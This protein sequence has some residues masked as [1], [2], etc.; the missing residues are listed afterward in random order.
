MAAAA[1][2]LRVYQPSV[3]AQAIATGSLQVEP[4]EPQQVVLY[5]HYASI[6]SQRA[7]LVLVEKQV[8]F[9]SVM[10]H[11]DKFE[12]ISPTYLGINPRGLVPTIVADGEVVFDSATIM[13]YVNNRFVGPD[14]TPGDDAQ[15]S[16]IKQ[17]IE[18]ADFF[19]IRD[20]VFRIAKERGEHGATY[21]GWG[22]DMVVRFI[23]T[24]KEY[25][26][27]YPEF[28]ENYQLK[29]QDWMGQLNRI[30]E[31]DT[32][33]NSKQ[34]TDETMD[35]FD[36]R[37]ASQDYI[38]GNEY[39]LADITWTPILIRLQYALDYKIWGDGLRPNLER[40]FLER[41]KARPGFKPAIIDHYYGDVVPDNLAA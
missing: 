35:E 31:D 8:S 11:Y 24:M 34:Y 27:Q 21:S 39:S 22:F 17:E 28:S 4:S 5:S 33:A 2:D 37:L 26:Q 14:L 18:T 3:R 13:Q 25:Q 29:L 19:P 36:R 30:N 7:R 12:T 16:L 23:E 10:L 20:L 41:I 38:V 9:K 32:I 15:K 6:C 40:Y 1:E